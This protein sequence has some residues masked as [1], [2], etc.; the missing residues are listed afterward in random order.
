MA[1]PRFR[2]GNHEFISPDEDAPASRLDEDDRR[3]IAG[4][5]PPTH[6]GGCVREADGS[7]PSAFL[8]DGEW[9]GHGE[10]TF[11]V[12]D[13]VLDGTDELEV[14]VETF[15]SMDEEDEGDEG[16]PVRRVLVRPSGSHGEWTVIHDATWGLDD[17]LNRVFPWTPDDRVT[18]DDPDIQPVLTEDDQPE[19]FRVSIGLEYPPDAQSA[20]DISWVTIIASGLAADD[21]EDDVFCLVSEEMA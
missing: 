15:D 20:G 16:P 3:P 12:F 2:L 13:V 10:P 1:S 18:D 11:T 4:A 17:D 8:S 9:C 21:D 5:Q 7:G 14:A 19:K 6:L